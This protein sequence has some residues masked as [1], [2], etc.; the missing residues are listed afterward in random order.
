[1]WTPDVAWSSDPDVDTTLTGRIV[2]E[3]N[4]LIVWYIV[5][6]YSNL[7]DYA[8]IILRVKN[9]MNLNGMDY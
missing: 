3:T 8:N 9:R 7:L 4:K 2:D 6:I 5:L 1:M